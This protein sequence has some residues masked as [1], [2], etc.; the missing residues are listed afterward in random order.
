[1]RTIERTMR[2]CLLFFILGASAL[3][4]G[5]QTSTSG[6]FR[7]VSTGTPS[8]SQIS[9]QISGSVPSGTATTEVL[10][11]TLR[12]AIAR[13]VRYNLGV[14][15]SGEN[16]RN[17]RGQ[18][19]LALSG[20]LPRL[21]AGAI[22]TVSKASTVPS[23]ISQARIIRIPSVIG[24][25]SFSEASGNLAWTLFSYESIERFRAARTAEEAAKLSYNDTLDVITLSVGSGYLQVTEAS[26]RI[27]A[28]EAQV[29]N[30]E[31]TY[32]QALR[33][34]QAGTAPRIDVTRTQVQLHTEQYNLIVARNNLAIAKLNLSRAIG[35]PL[36][37]AFE[38]ADTVPYSEIAPPTID[39]AL[40]SAFAARSD[41]L[42]ARAAQK[43]AER[44]LSAAKAQ[45][46]PVASTSGNYSVVGPTFG[47]SQGI[48]SFQAGI[49]VPLF[50]GG[51]IKGDITQADAALR[52]RSAEA[53]N[54]R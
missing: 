23:G 42:A 37:Q 4:A 32:N 44:T 20:L 34:F 5:A 30:A 36:G 51:Q 35:L 25:F 28:K 48:F 22:E 43:A 39:E 53:E 41:F 6:S 9:S 47:Q 21:T 45:R 26:S 54:I 38:I 24:P 1:V 17:A 3:S 12:D 29:R 10:R 2:N 7:L 40:R 11:L 46:Y 19:L 27:T 52:Q 50:T 13:A 31:A 15:E 33:R 18:R 14:T 16:A 8:T 49:S